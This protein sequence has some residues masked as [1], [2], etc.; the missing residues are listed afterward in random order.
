MVSGLCLPDPLFETVGQQGLSK[1]TF[2]LS[3][4]QYK[5]SEQV[6]DVPVA[7]TC[8]GK[9]AEYWRD[10]LVPGGTYECPCWVKTRSWQ[11]NGRTMYETTLTPRDVHRVA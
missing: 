10:N 8:Y 7:V 2:V 3:T 6:D 11:A 9:I 1:L 4:A 5:G